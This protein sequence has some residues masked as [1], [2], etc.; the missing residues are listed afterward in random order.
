MKERYSYLIAPLNMAYANIDEQVMLVENLKSLAD[1]LEDPIVIDMFREYDDM[2]FGKKKLL[3]AN[4]KTVITSKSQIGHLL[5][6]ANFEHEQ[7]PELKFQV[8]DTAPS[9]LTLENGMHARCYSLYSTPNKL[10]AGWIYRI[11][12]YCDFVRIFVRPVNPSLYVSMLRG[13]I[14]TAHLS[15]KKDT[16]DGSAMIEVMKDKVLS[17]NQSQIV[18]VRV[19]FGV[20]GSTRGVLEERAKRF[21][22]K[23][24]AM[25]ATL[26]HLPYSDETFLRAG[27]TDIYVET[28]SLH[29]I[30]PFI[31]S[32]LSEKGGTAW[33][34]NVVTKRAV[35]Y[36][37]KKRRNYNVGIVATSGAGK[38]HTIK[39]IVSRAQKKYSD[40]FFFF[41]DIENEY[42]E[43]GK[44]LGFSIS[45]IDINVELGMD[46]FNYMSRYKAASLLAD[47]LG[48]QKL[49]RYAM[50]RAGEDLRCTSTQRMIEIIAQY[51]GEES[52]EHAKY[53]QILQMGPIR[54]LLAG[55]PSMSN[56]SV[57]ALAN[58]FAVNSD[59]HR[60]ATRI[61]LEFALQHATKLPK[62]IPKFVVLDE[63]WALFKD[64]NTGE[65]VEELARRARKYNVIIILATQNIE[66]VLKHA[67][68]LTLFNN[69]DTKIFL[70][71]KAN[72]QGALVD[73]LHL[74]EFEARILVRAKKGEAMV[75]ASENVVRCQF[76]A[77][78]KEMELFNTDPNEP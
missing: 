58:S 63:G 37:Y 77:D 1:S 38:S 65:S 39:I 49:T 31:S 40:A 5:H 32:E 52:T 36:D 72:E 34:L 74:S 12:Q 57:I 66:D 9:Y 70:Q 11:F 21:G 64:E 43:F 22:S 54:S 23:A 50:L 56:S 17:Q 62:I 4:E 2:M 25:R 59:E 8:K 26:R 69:S 48:V 51:D 10:D 27:R 20:L 55:M 33:G 75:H 73:V 42:V 76:I 7:I 61:S 6:Q 45:E 35:L 47:V 29:P 14:K 18:S 3:C 78:E 71:H 13:S 16:I 30:F 60:L 28:D 19:V 15:A 53:M 67:H 41:V 68:A 46:P 24:K 44:R